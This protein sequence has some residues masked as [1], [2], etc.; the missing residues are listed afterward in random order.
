M[1]RQLFE[2]VTWG[3]LMNVRMCLELLLILWCFKDK[4]SKLTSYLKKLTKGCLMVQ[5]RL[6]CISM[7]GVIF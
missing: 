3:G 2:L 6:L 5:Q 7:H 1:V 4:G